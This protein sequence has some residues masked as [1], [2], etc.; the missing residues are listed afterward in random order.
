MNDIQNFYT[1]LRIIPST[2][3][4]WNLDNLTALT[5]RPLSSWPVLVLLC[6]HNLDKVTT[7]LIWPPFSCLRIGPIIKGPLYVSIEW[8]LKL[9]SLM[10]TKVYSRRHIANTPCSW[11]YHYG[12]WQNTKYQ[13]LISCRNNRLCWKIIA[14]FF[15]RVTPQTEKWICL[16]RLIQQDCRPCWQK[17]F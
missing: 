4:Q 12:L 17:G 14:C 13:I 5:K 16:F 1:H 15:G 2:L 7:P 3:V 10:Y 6:L 8:A 9:H 11:I